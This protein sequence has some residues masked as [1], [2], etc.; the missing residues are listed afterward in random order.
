MTRGETYLPEHWRDSNK[1]HPCLRGYPRFI[2]KS[3]IL[4]DVGHTLNEEL[5]CGRLWLLGAIKKTRVLHVFSDKVR[6]L[7]M[8]IEIEVI[9]SSGLALDSEEIAAFC[10]REILQ[11]QDAKLDEL[12]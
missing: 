11:D 2:K 3:S 9:K 1:W 8:E 12:I 10:E 4:A 7:Q 5:P 6:Q